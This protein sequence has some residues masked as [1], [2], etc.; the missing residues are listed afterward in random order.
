[1]TKKTST[2]IV[3]KVLPALE[4][5]LI[6]IDELVFDPD[7]AQV[8]PI[9]NINAIKKSLKEHGQDQLIVVREVDNVVCKGNGRLRAAINLGWTHIA[10]VRVDEDRLASI[11]RSIADNKTGSMSFA[12]DEQL[13][14]LLRELQTDMEATQ[15]TFQPPAGFT[16][17]EINELCKPFEAPDSTKDK[18]GSTAPKPDSSPTAKTST[19]GEPVPLV[20]QVIVSCDTEQEQSRVYEDLHKKG[21]KC[22][23]LIS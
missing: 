6:P 13:E 22:R 14:K 8:H 3:C 7:N 23:V 2:T 15:K 20:Y 21:H 10:G 19:S 17:G 12:D 16:V 9:E 18:D 1:M 11:R 5:F 4:N